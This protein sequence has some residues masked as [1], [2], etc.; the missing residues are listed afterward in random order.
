MSAAAGRAAGKVG[1]AAGRAAAKA[2][3]VGS[4]KGPDGPLNKGAKRDPELY[5]LATIMTGAFGM[6][7]YYFGIQPWE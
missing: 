6:A 4:K 3:E 7:G 1:Q 5:I 2:N